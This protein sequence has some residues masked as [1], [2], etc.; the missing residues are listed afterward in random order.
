[1]SRHILSLSVCLLLSGGCSIRF[2]GAQQVRWHIADVGGATVEPGVRTQLRSDLVREMRYRGI[3][4]GELQLKVEIVGLTHSRSVADPKSG[5]IGWRSTLILRAWVPAVDNCDAEVTVRRSWLGDGA[6]PAV[7]SAA[8]RTAI[9]NMA[10]LASER[11]LD[12]L[13][14][15]ASCR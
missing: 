4:P 12:R 11:A 13:L 8:R 1:M 10:K 15:I 2:G 7:A 3:N 14:S 5:D 6:S 9:E